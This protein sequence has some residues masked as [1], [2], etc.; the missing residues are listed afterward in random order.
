MS[1]GQGPDGPGIAVNVSA[2]QLE[3]D[4]VLDHVAEALEATGLPSHSLELEVTQTSMIE[5][6]DVVAPRMAALRAL[7]VRLAIDDFGVGYSSLAQ[8]RDLPVDCVKVDRS[9]VAGVGTS[10]GDR[11][12]V[13][14]IVSLARALNLSVVAEGVGTAEEAATVTALGC[15]RA[16]G[17]F[18]S[19]P[20]PSEDV[21]L[22]EKEHAIIAP[23]RSC[24][25][26]SGVG[27]PVAADRLRPRQRNIG[28]VAEATTSTSD[29]SG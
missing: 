10:P 28:C 16:Q 7:G 1:W 3:T 23:S 22:E 27:V 25:L 20:V 4:A 26:P 12:L 24:T 13:A 2:R 19:Q 17:F 5:R 14:G 11:A 29:G 8:L 18:Y 6:V 21:R 15:H 9:F